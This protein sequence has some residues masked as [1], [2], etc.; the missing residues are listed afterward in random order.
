MYMVECPY[1]EKDFDAEEIYDKQNIDDRGYQH[2][3]SCGK[4]IYI[5]KQIEVTYIVEC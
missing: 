2:C 3:P 5:H 4:E 1:C